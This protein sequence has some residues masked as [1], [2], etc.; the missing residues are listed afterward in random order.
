MTLLEFYEMVNNDNKDYNILYVGVAIKCSDGVVIAEPTNPR[1]WTYKFL[2]HFGDVT[3]S[4]FTSTPKREFCS[5]YFTVWID[6]VYGC[7]YVTE[8]Y[9]PTPYNSPITYYRNDEIFDDQKEEY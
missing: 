9:L 3:I 8:T 4:G 5:G 2:K 7:D 6:S 1:N